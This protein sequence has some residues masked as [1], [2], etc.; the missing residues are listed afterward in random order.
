[1]YISCLCGSKLI[2]FENTYLPYICRANR[3]HFAS[4]QYA[5]HLLALRLVNIFKNSQPQSY[6]S[7]T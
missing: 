7:F 5:K 1:M 2:F 3:L 6:S 4:F